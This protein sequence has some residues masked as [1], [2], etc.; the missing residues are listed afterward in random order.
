MRFLRPT[1]AVT[2]AKA[3]LQSG[4]SI[5]VAGAS[6]TLDFDRATGEP[7]AQFRL[8]RIQGKSFIHE[9]NFECRGP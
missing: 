7:P 3:V 5:D 1:G 2:A 6:G 9:R 4:R 8:W